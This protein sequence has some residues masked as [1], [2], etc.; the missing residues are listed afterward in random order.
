METDARGQL[1]GLD[2]SETER[3]RYAEASGNWRCGVCGR[4][5]REI[6]AETAEAA[7]AN[8]IV[9]GEGSRRVDEEIP[10]E[11][12][13]KYKDSFEGKGQGDDAEEAELA[14]GFVQTTPIETPPPAYPPA[15][16]AQGVPQPTGSAS[17]GIDSQSPG[18]EAMQNLQQR[19]T[20][21]TAQP[22][23][24]MRA[25]AAEVR[26]STD[27]VPIWIDRAI[28]GVVVCLI[29]MVL[30]VILTS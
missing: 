24:H 15:R 26:R 17:T 20:V 7:K 18:A 3:K 11:L 25:R 19:N 28:A 29:I 1:G 27:G 22:V 9:N 23:Q 6:L 13:M 14:E 10:K 8:E 4:S 5:N 21:N 12:T 30:K 16:P 2:T